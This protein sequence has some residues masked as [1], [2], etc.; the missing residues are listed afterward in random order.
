MLP[1][2]DYMYAM[3]RRMRQVGVFGAAAVS[4]VLVPTGGFG[5][6]AASPNA[7]DL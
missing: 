6:S 1:Q 4:V 2:K 7:V 5:V 3:P